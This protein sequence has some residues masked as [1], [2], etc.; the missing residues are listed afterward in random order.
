MTNE[1]KLKI[2]G[3]DFTLPISYDWFPDEE[4]LL[5]IQKEA[6]NVLIK[7]SKVIDNAL[8]DLKAYCRKTSS[9]ISAE[10]EIEN[11]FK[12][13]IP[14]KFYVIRNTEKRC[15]ALLCDYKFDM[16]HGIAIVFE[17]ECLK[18]IGTQDLVL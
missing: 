15:V 10:D 6:I 13:V 8:S 18:N 3:R 5:E 11:I 14:A 9:E 4:E 12:Y 2:W 7:N 17:N 1:I 16:E